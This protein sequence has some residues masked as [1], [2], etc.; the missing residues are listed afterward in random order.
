MDNQ[1]NF[2]AM[3]NQN[4][5]EPAEINPGANHLPDAGQSDDFGLAAEQKHQRLFKSGVTW[6]CIGLLFMAISFGVNFLLFHSE[7]SF[8][9]AMYILTTMGMVCITKG[10]ADILGF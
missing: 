2:K 6:L 5:P 8:T 1:S 4:T 7:Q 10:I 9:T 3:Q